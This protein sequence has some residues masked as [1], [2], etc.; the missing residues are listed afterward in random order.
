M[1]GVGFFWFWGVDVEV[2]V[3]FFEVVFVGL[4]VVVWVIDVSLG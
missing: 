1:F 3:G 2:F 4:L